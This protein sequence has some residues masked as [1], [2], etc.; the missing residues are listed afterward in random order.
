MKPLLASMRCRVPDAHPPDQLGRDV[1]GI[2]HR[3]IRHH[4]EGQVRFVYPSEG[5]PGG[6]KRRAYPFTGVAMD[7]TAAIPIVIPGP[8]TGPVPHGGM[9]GVA[10][11]VALP[12]VRREPRAVG[13]QV[14]GH[15]RVAGAPVRMI[16]PPEARLA[17]LPRDHADQ[18]RTIVGIGAVS[19]ALMA[20]RLP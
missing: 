20:A 5:A 11:M 3:F 18:G 8:F 4:L 12:L 10:A 7:L 9:G 1:F 13:R 6:A 15:Q 16:T 2:D 14:L 17:R 19:C